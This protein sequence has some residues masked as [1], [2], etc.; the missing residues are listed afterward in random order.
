MTVRLDPVP[1][2]PRWEKQGNT[3]WVACRSCN[4]WFPV[5]GG[6]LADGSIAL[7]CPHCAD[8]FLP[9]DAARVIQP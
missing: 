6:L 1:S 4:G 3:I 8:M 2:P 9:P 5:E 7:K